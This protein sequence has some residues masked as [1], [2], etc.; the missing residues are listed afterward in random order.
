MNY[1]K[2]LSHAVDDF[3]KQNAFVGNTPPMNNVSKVDV[4]LLAADPRIPGE[5]AMDESGKILRKY[6]VQNTMGS[7][8]VAS[9]NHLVQYTLPRIISM[10]IMHNTNQVRMAQSTGVQIRPWKIFFR[11]IQTYTPMIMDNGTP[12][13]LYPV[14]AERRNLTY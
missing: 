5:F 10:Y 4:D 9:F 12:S 6:L 3:Q 8:L 13:L 7:D 14:V 11:N 1:E 2:L